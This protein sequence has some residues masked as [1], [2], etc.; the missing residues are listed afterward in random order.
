MNSHAQRGRLQ[1]EAAGGTV[2]GRYALPAAGALESDSMPTVVAV[3]GACHT[4]EYFDLTPRTS[5][6][7]VGSALGFPVIAVDRPAY[8]SATTLQTDD[9]G[10]IAGWLA[11]V[12]PAVCRHLGLGEP[13]VVVVGHSSGAAIAL[14]LA[15]R[16]EAAF[17]LAG[18]SLVGIGPRPSEF[19][20]K[21]EA[22][23]PAEGM[24]DPPP[25]QGLRHA[26]Y[27]APTTYD[28]AV[29]ALAAKAMVP[30]PASELR[31]VNHFSSRLKEILGSLT[32]P[33][34]FV[35]PEFDGIWPYSPDHLQELAANLSAAPR[36]DATMLPAAGH[37]ADHHFTGRALHLRQLAFAAEAAIT[38]KEG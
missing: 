32:L 11:A 20:F 10:S 8:G 24:V 3:H 38:C 35:M 18:V 5:L 31:Q 2:A 33:V 34:Q 37:A 21:V 27:A 17:V 15:A 25:E 28:D 14:E 1:V 4:S 16:D 19:V 7:S 36:V 30:G 12:V 23:L 29:P 22:S 13:P 26:M 9:L 6:L